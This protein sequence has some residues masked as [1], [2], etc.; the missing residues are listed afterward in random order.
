MRSVE[1]I[2]VFKDAPYFFYPD[3]FILVRLTIKGLQISAG[4]GGGFTPFLKRRSK[5]DVTEQPQGEPPSKNVEQLKIVEFTADQDFKF[6]GNSRVR[7]FNV[8]N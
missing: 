2:A 8:E 6:M 3:P 5:N 4:S 7:G 1:G